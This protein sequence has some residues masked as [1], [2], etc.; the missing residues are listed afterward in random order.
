[1]TNKPDKYLG[2]PITEVVKHKYLGL[3]IGIPFIA[4][5]VFAIFLP[6]IIFL[7][8]NTTAGAEYDWQ[9]VGYFHILLLMLAVLGLFPLADY[10]QKCQLPSDLDTEAYLKSINPSVSKQSN[11]WDY[12]GYMIL[13]GSLDFGITRKLN[14]IGKISLFCLIVLSI[15]FSTFYVVRGEDAI[16][17]YILFSKSVE[18]TYSETSGFIFQCRLSEK[19]GDVLY[20]VYNSGDENI[21]Y[22]SVR[23]NNKKKEERELIFSKIPK[24]EYSLE[25][26]KC[27]ASDYQRINDHLESLGLSANSELSQIKL[28]DI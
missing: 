26:S 8:T 22:N 2:K 18:L 5:I 12:I 21:I 17:H 15:V 1:M 27:E 7:L 28:L 6:S 9:G 16:T 10:M 13:F 24:K 19:H 3:F 4:F 20:M 11:L 23:D 25:L 14:K